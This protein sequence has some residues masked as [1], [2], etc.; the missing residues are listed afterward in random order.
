MPKHESS[1][2]RNRKT[3]LNLIQ[4]GRGQ[5][6]GRCYVPWLLAHQEH[7]DGTTLR[8]YNPLTGRMHHLFTRKM[9]WY[10]FEMCFDDTVTDIR[11]NFALLPRERTIRLAEEAGIP[12][13]RYSESRD[14]KVL[15]FDFVINRGEQITAV[16]LLSERSLKNITNERIF[17]IQELYCKEMGWEFLP[18]YKEDMN[19]H[20]TN[21][22]RRILAPRAYTEDYYDNAMREHF[23]DLYFETPMPQC[24][25]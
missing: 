9:I 3:D 12:F 14:K 19:M 22:I 6:E 11:E 23:L 17:H 10:Y 2:P 20:R 13:P 21:N 16:T 25:W 24:L 8:I 7:I 15:L 5:G 18:A 1:V 4:M